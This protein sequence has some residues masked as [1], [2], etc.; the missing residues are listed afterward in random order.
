MEE[1]LEVITWQQLGFHAKPIALL[2]IDGFYDTLLTFFSQCTEAGFVKEQH[3]RSILV[4]AGAG[5]CI[6][7]KPLLRSYLMT[8]T[9]AQPL[10][11]PLAMVA[12]C[13][14]Y[15]VLVTI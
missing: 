14:R 3:S 1:L 11:G 2:N 10:V 6:A 8:R 7:S 4:S 13:I 15:P 12:P 9:A 5:L